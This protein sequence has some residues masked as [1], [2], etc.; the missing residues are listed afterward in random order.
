MSAVSSTQ[1]RGT[2]TGIGSEASL[3]GVK[4]LARK[5]AAVQQKVRRQIAGMRTNLSPEERAKFDEHNK[6]LGTYT[7]REIDEYLTEWNEDGKETITCA[8]G[9]ERGYFVL[10]DESRPL[11][12]TN[13]APV[14][15]T[16]YKQAQALWG[17]A[18]P[19]LEQVIQADTAASRW[20]QETNPEFPLSEY[21]LFLNKAREVL[22]VPKA[23]LNYYN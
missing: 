10:L 1:I 14:C 16:F 23:D 8:H 7:R 21:R 18:C 20:K 11:S 6:G 5:V 17:V 9:R 12:M 2:G 3:K 19:N 4:E 22:L 13:I 15:E